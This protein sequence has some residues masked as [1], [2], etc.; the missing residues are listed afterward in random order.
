MPRFRARPVALI[1]TLGLAAWGRVGIRRPSDSRPACASSQSRIARYLRAELSDIVSDS[2]PK[3]AELRARWGIRA[4]PRDSVAILV[5]DSVCGR[6]T[7]AYSGV[8]PSTIRDTFAVA[9][10]GALRVVVPQP[11]GAAST[12]PIDYRAVF[13]ADFARLVDFFPQ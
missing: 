11:P 9:R 12:R 3:H 6:A 2:Q 7:A 5:D 13:S 10:V 8:F 1:A 4:L